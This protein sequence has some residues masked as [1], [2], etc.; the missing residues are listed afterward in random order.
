MI[1]AI[2]PQNVV[3][4][5]SPAPEFPVVNMKCIVPGLEAEF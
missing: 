5:L 3:L 2:G 1:K 4:L